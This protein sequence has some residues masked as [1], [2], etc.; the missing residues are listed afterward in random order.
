[1]N[2]RRLA[3]RIGKG[4]AGLLLGAG[5]IQ[6]VAGDEIP[7]WTGDKVDYGAL[8]ALTVGLSLLAGFAAI[9]QR[10]GSLSVLARAACA[11]GIIGPGLLAL[12]T[13]GRLAYLPAALL[14]IAGVLAVQGWSASWSAVTANWDRVLLS[15]LG[16]C[17]LLMVAAG[18]ARMIIVGIFG[19]LA[20]VT[21]ASRRTVPRRTLVSLLALGTVPI[22]A[23]GWTTVVPVILAM[24]TWLIAI[25]VLRAQASRTEEVT[26]ARTSRAHSSHCAKVDR[27]AEP[28]SSSAEKLRLLGSL[29][30]GPFVDDE[31]ATIEGIDL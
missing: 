4:G 9:R 15:A 31:P 8:G 24:T 25:P 22:A 26:S 28:G 21:A 1:M 13:V 18:P 2:R 23:L 10:D 17:E 12:T 14:T 20:L 3:S 29:A 19:G 7:E 6:A 30:A 11:A 5:L 16:G 27:V